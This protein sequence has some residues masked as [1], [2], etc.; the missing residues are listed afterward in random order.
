MPKHHIR[1]EVAPEF[2]QP[3]LG[4]A[5]QHELRALA[6]IDVIYE[7]Q[8]QALE[9]S[10]IP[11]SIKEH[12]ARELDAKRASSRQPHEQRLAHLRDEILRLTVYRDQTV[13]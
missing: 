11:A 4:L 9:R 6:D 5:L 7:E 12:L 8:R 3:E 13:H 10:A 1:A 2:Y